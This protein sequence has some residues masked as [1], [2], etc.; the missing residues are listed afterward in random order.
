MVQSLGQEDPEGGNGNPFQYPCLENSTDRGPWWATVCG[1][2][3]VEHDCVSP[4]THN[5]IY[6]I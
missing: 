2:Q 5:R 6:Y 4:H 3:R 1:L